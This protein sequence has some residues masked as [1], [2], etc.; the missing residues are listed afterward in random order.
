MLRKLLIGVI[1]GFMTLSIHARVIEVEGSARIV[2]GDTQAARS[3]AIENALQQALLMTGSS[4]TSVQSIVNGV[5][6]NNQTQVSA[7]GNVERVDVLREEMRDGRLYVLIQTEIWQREQSCRG[8]HYK[9]GVTIAPFEFSNREHAAYGQ[10]WTLGNISAQHL[11]RDIASQSDQLF[12]TH[13]LRRNAGLQAALDNL[14][15]NEVGRIGRQIGYANDSQFVILGIF[16]DLSVTEQ[17]SFLG[18]FEQQP[19]RHFALTLYLIDAMNGDLITRARVEGA[20]PWT[21]PRNAQVDVA[22][23]TFWDAPF[24]VALA[25]SLE[26]LASGIQMQV[27]C[28]P[29][30]GRVVWHDRQQVQVNLGES[31]GVKVGDKLKIVHPSNYVDDQGHFRQRWQVSRFTVTVE[32]VQPDSAVASINGPDVLTN[33]QVNDWVVPASESDT[34]VAQ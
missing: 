29:V 27:Q 4:I 25:S 16:D 34:T 19:T 18:V 30:R 12:V 15:L 32:Q 22:T 20:E 5:V 2:N 9:A 8:S 28:K 26:E 1:V 21:F 11:A 33:V 13:T 24:G 31:H 23:T 7:T 17:G 10:I 14:N 6:N 3:Q